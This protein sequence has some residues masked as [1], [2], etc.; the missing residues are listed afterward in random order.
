MSESSSTPTSPLTRTLLA[1]AVAGAVAKT[2]TAPLDRVKILFQTSAPRYVHYS[3]S[4][5]GPFNTLRHIANQEGI[6]GLYRGHALM[7][8]RIVPYAAVQFAAYE[9]YKEVK[10][11]GYIAHLYRKQISMGGRQDKG[12]A[13]SDFYLS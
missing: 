11:I 13:Q 6:Q 2:A 10:S 12:L 8:A 7:L 3:R 1:G 5:Q 9:Y 4:W